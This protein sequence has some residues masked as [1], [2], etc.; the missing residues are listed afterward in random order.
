MIIKSKMIEYC[1]T[2]ILYWKKPNLLWSRVGKFWIFC[3]EKQKGCQATN[4]CI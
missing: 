1:H 4:R 2:V 3:I